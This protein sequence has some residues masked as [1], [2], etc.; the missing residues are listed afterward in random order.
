MRQVFA[1]PRMK[2]VE[3]VADMLREEGIEVRITQGRSYKGSWGGRRS[4]RDS[5]G[6]LPAVWVVKSEDQPRARQLLRDAGLLDSTRMPSDS[7]LGPSLHERA[8]K[9]V[10][11]SPQRRAFRYKLALLVAIAVAIALAYSVMRT[12]SPVP[13]AAPAAPAAPAAGPAPAPAATVPRRETQAAVYRVETPPALAELLIATELEAHRAGAACL[14]IDGKAPPADVLA[15]L[16]RRGT[17]LTAMP[18]CP[19]EAGSLAIDVTD[20]RTDGSGTG[21]VEVRVS[22]PGADG[23]ASMQ[24]RRLQV[25]RIGSDWRVLRVLDVR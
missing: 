9:G 13:V 11:P 14:G 4:Y 12:P 18:D 23:A 8:E 3:G 1:S 16:R 10:A 15:H 19:A 21:T 5:E 17:T 24:V 6:A 25:Q 20:Y 2:N 22:A 7:Y